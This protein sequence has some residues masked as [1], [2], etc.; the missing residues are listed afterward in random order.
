MEIRKIRLELDTDRR[1]ASVRVVLPELSDAAGAICGKLNRL[2][3]WSR[4]ETSGRCQ[5]QPVMLLRIAERNADPLAPERLKH[6]VH[7]LSDELL[8]CESTFEQELRVA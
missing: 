8:R 4:I 5:G 2:G 1:G 3:F 7:E 6:M